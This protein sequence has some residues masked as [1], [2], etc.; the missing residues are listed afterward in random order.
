MVVRENNR[1]HSFL[2]F[3]FKERGSL[4]N[5]E[6]HAMKMDCFE[7]LNL[8][9]VE[10]DAFSCMHLT[11]RLRYPFAPPCKILE[12]AALTIWES[13]SLII[14]QPPTFFWIQNM[15]LLLPDSSKDG[16]MAGLKAFRSEIHALLGIHHRNNAKLLISVPIGKRGRLRT[17]LNSDQEQAMEMDWIKRLSLVTGIVN[18]LSCVNHGCSSPQTQLIAWK[19]LL[20]FLLISQATRNHECLKCH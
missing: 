5:C 12:P 20:D 7:K 16:E 3:E 15:G 18:A 17:D 2:V 9:Q 14:I 10:A 19:N 1:K 13:F 6:E 4:M 11:A 8:A